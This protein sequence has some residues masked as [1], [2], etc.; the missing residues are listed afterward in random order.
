[1]ASDLV[2]RFTRPLW[3]PI[4]ARFDRRLEVLDAE[5]AARASSL[6]NQLVDLRRRL[7]QLDIKVAEL[8]RRGASSD[9]VAA[10]REDIWHSKVVNLG[11]RLLVGARH[12]NLVFLVDP[13][14]R[15]I[16]PRFIVDGEYEPE[17]TAFMRRVVNETSVCIDVGAN[18][19]Y[20]SCLLGHLAW[21]GR[22]LAYEA[23]P[24][25][26]RLL[27]DNVWIN[28]CSAIVE[29]HNAAVADRDG[30]LRLY[31]RLTR[32]GNTSIIESTPEELE[33]LDEPAS[34]PF[35]VPAIA[36]DSLLVHLSRVDLVKIDVEGAEALVL[37]G[38][39]ELVA[40]RHPTIVM[41]WSPWQTRR[42]GFEVSKLVSLIGELDLIPHRI[43]PG[44][45]T[46]EISLDA[47]AGLTYQ[48]LVLIPR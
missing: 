41:E 35:D 20:Y 23:D 9:D 34:E 13:T 48:N 2:K 45:T 18:F 37:E 12:L 5:D 8:G 19:G 28:W 22:V 46:E 1:M 21:R 15:L 33:A 6:R 16:G 43:G 7:E 38:M 26:H 14:D 3:A 29:P 11:D 10:L 27:R 24:E 25:V 30:T 36:L 39:R 4:L 44:G 47:L 31:R 17:T 42:A 40:R 32:A